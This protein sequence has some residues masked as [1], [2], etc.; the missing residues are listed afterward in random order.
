M[1]PDMLSYGE[2]LQNSLISDF[3]RAAGV[4]WEPGNNFV[5]RKD[6]FFCFFLIHYFESQ[7]NFARKAFQ[8]PQH[9]LT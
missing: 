4:S 8:C 1:A 6:F 7:I 2:S 3:T 5:K 9:Y